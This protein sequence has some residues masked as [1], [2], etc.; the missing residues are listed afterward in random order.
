VQR[1]VKGDL[2]NFRK[3]IE[4]RCSGFRR[5]REPRH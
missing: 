4:E 3:F 2:E 5:G 1:R